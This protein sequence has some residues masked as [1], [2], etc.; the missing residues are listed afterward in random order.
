[1]GHGITPPG[2]SL[3]NNTD[4]QLPPPHGRDE[5]GRTS[6]NKLQPGARSVAPKGAEEFRQKPHG[7]WPE[8]S[9]PEV[10]ILDCFRLGSIECGAN[11]THAA[12]GLPQEL[13][14]DFRQLNSCAAAQEKF[15]A[16]F[17]FDVSNTPAYRGL[18][19]P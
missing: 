12:S 14:T 8:E 1:M 19:D 2:R 13:A 11:V 9:D 10:P 3:G 6:L 7:Q 17:L 18:L 5:F 4:I 16:D 15:G